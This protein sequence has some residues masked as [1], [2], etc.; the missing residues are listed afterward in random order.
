MAAGALMIA[1]IAG[2]ASANGLDAVAP[3][4]AVEGFEV[5]GAGVE[6]GVAGVWALAATAAA[7]IRR[8]KTV[9]FIVDLNS[10]VS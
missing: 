8:S 4:F 7:A 1:A 10:K 6:D 9:C 5:A 3:A 2:E